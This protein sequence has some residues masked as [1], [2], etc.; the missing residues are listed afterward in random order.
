MQLI[1]LFSFINLCWGS[2]IDSFTHRKKMLEI[3]FPSANNAL[4]LLMN[5][6]LEDALTSTKDCDHDN[7]LNEVRSRLA[8]VDP[9]KLSSTFT[10]LHR[11]DMLDYLELYVNRGKFTLTNGT[12]ITIPVVRTSQEEHVYRNFSL[13][14]EKGAITSRIHFGTVKIIDKLTGKGL[15]IGSDKFG[16][17]IS[18]GLHILQTEND[19]KKMFEGSTLNQ[20]FIDYIALLQGL[21]MTV[22]T[23][24][25]YLG[26]GKNAMGLGTGLFSYADLC[27]NV[28]GKFF[29]ENLLGDSGNSYFVCKNGKLEKN[30]NFTWSDYINP[31]WDESIN[32]TELILPGM[33][34]KVLNNI[35][36]LFQE[37][38]LP[39]NVPP[40]DLS[41]CASMKNHTSLRPYFNFIINP[42]CLKEVL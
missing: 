6:R 9:T 28:A 5:D 31:C 14:A 20:Q 17:F 15:I 23:E 13:I 18:E 35:D 26:M 19:F 30:R 24:A 11:L 7:L 32:P 41:L 21:T 3:E 39:R 16:H 12:Q 10:Q 40:M 4:D 25:T 37:G 42:V 2:E 22:S 36:R 8:M 1:I 34:D 29:W 38:K 27:S 33:K